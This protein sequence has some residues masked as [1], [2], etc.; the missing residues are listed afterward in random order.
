MEIR[1]RQDNTVMRFNDG[2]IQ[3]YS[4]NTLGYIRDGTS[5]EIEILDASSNRLGVVRSGVSQEFEVLDYSSNRVGSMENGLSGELEV[6]DYSSNRLG[7]VDSNGNIYDSGYNRL[8]EFSGSIS[9]GLIAAIFFF[10]PQYFDG[11]D[12]EDESNLEE[13]TSPVYSGPTL[14]D[15]S[16]EERAVYL[17]EREKN[18]YIE[19]DDEETKELM[20]R[21]QSGGFV[22]Q[23]LTKVFK[24]FS[25]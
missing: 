9:K 23:L 5:E 12:G 17:T 20:R 7:S 21:R 16:P 1:D 22:N 6:F 13:A 10:Y 8:G 19:E 4:S 25:K 14:D 15:L 11:S 3:D 18:I 2:L 24:M